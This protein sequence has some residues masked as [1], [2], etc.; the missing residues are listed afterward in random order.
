MDKAAALVTGGAYRIGRAIAQSLAQAGHPVAIH[1]HRSHA[2]AQDLADQIIA[3]GGKACVVVGDLQQI[4]RL[5]PIVADAQTALGA[6]GILVN[7]ASLFEDDSIAD[8]TPKSL[9]AHLNVNLSAPC[10]L[11]SAVAKLLP[12]DRS[13]LI[14]NLIDQRVLRPNPQFFSYSMAK[15]GLWWATKTMAQA[16]APRIRVVAI[17]PGPTLP[18]VRQSKDDFMRQQQAVL[19]HRGPDLGEFGATIE[20]ILRTPSLTG[21]LIALDG[22]QHL[23]WETP[24]ISGIH[25]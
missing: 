22:G 15:A 8:L 10:L 21:Q 5:E 6:I 2:A 16:L 23:A 19:L 17:A 20:W 13:G 14:V 9:T 4:D 7:N 1:C 25:E 18:S 24:D 12:Q 3:S 11:A